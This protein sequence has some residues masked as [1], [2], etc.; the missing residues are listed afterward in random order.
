MPAARSGLAS[1]LYR[2]AFSRSS[3]AAIAVVVTAIFFE[4]GLD[5]SADKIF[6]YFNE[7]VRS[8]TT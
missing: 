1:T 2:L 7:G 3:S 6:D 5:Y 8:S 4:R